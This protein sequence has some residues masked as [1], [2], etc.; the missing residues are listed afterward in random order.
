MSARG[1]SFKAIKLNQIFGREQTS[2]I[3]TAARAVTTNKP[4]GQLHI[5]SI[6]N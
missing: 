1:R 3:M 4:K 5:N 6:G 2:A